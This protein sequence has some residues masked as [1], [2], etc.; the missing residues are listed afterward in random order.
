MV[1]CALVGCIVLAT[2]GT[3]E[4]KTFAGRGELNLI[5][6]HDRNDEDSGVYKHAFLVSSQNA[7]EANDPRAADP[8]MPLFHFVP[9]PFDWCVSGAC[10]RSLLDVLIPIQLRCFE[11]FGSM[12]FLVSR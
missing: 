10:H 1:W 9:W 2:N 6:D 4:R 12:C 5:S 8:T 11:L 3:F 7:D